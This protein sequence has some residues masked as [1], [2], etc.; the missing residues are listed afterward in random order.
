MPV[1]GDA[2]RAR[3][4]GRVRGWERNS[5]LAILIVTTALLVYLAWRTGVTVDEPAHLVSA[6]LYWQGNDVLRPGDMPPLIKMVSGWVPLFFDLPLPPDLGKEGETR[7][8]WEVSLAMMERLPWKG[9][10]P[11]FFWTRLPMLVFP[12]LTI[13]VVWRWVRELPR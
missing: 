9:I 6:R 1:A 11:L 12:L 10:Q 8:E 4:A 13:V 7:H 5:I 3:S 2:I